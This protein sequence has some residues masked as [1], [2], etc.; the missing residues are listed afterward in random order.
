MN[1][2]NNVFTQKPS[3]CLILSLVHRAKR[4]SLEKHLNPVR[5][6]AVKMTKKENKETVNPLAAALK[7]EEK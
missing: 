2:H 3:A 1:L 7:E 6:T 5:P 4:L